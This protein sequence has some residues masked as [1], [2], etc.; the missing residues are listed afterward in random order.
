MLALSV[1]TDTR[2]IS[3]RRIADQMAIPEPILPSVMRELARAGL[4]EAVAGRSGGY[5]LA[6]PTAEITLLAI[7]EA[8]D[9][10]TRR[11]ECVLRGGA[12]GQDGA[13]AVHESF[14]AAHNAIR[15]ELRRATLD[16]LAARHPAS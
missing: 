3:V 6:R 8:I 13:C 11:Y 12:C 1:A 7:V 15:T 10:D 9:G 14:E 2:P 16:Q 5:R 4:V